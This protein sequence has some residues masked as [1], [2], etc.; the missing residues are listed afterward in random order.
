MILLN[1]IYCRETSP[2][3]DGTGNL[4]VQRESDGTGNLTVQRITLEPD[5]LYS[6]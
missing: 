2:C 6:S 3:D 1:A 4:T 5:N